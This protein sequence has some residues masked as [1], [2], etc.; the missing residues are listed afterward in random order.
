VGI[1]PVVHHGSLSA[2]FPNEL[3]HDETE[4]EREVDWSARA[5]RGSLGARAKTRAHTANSRTPSAKWR[6][7]PSR[8]RSYVVVNLVERHGSGI[9]VASCEELSNPCFPKNT[10]RDLDPRPHCSSKS[11]GTRANRCVFRKSTLTFSQMFFSHD[12]KESFCDVGTSGTKSFRLGE[13]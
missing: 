1:V 2:R 10:P 11:A 3:P 9:S 13:V 4:E 8:R 6:G 12:E 5:F 7:R